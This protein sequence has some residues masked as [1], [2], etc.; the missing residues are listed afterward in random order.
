MELASSQL[1]GYRKPWNI[2]QVADYLGYSVRTIQRLV[3][4]ERI[5]FK[6]SGGKLFFDPMKIAR[7]AGM[8]DEDKA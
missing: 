2:K 6:R 8:I 7:Y 5:P 3:Q 1:S 4:E